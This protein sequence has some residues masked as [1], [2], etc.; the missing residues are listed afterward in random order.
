MPFTSKSQMR[1]CYNKNDKRWDCDEF[2][3]ATPSVCCLP[4][5]IGSPARSRCMRKGERVKGKIQTGPR[6]GRFFTI[7]EKDKQGTVCTIKVYLR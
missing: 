2:L 5:R 3:R 7:T 4:E 1:T 6:G